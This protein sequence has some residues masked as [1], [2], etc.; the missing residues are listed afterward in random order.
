[1]KVDLLRLLLP[2][3][4]GD[5]VGCGYRSPDGAWSDGG[6]LPLAAVAARFHAKRVEVCLH[7]GDVPAASFA[8]PPLAGRR[9]RAAVLGAIEPCALQPLEGLVAG[10]GPRGAD[11]HVPAAW[12]ARDAMDGWVRLLRQHGLAM[13]ELRLPAAFLPCPAEGWVA[14]RIDQWLVV[15]TGRDQGFTQWLPEG[16]DRAAG[17][18]A[19][20]GEGAALPVVRWVG[21]EDGGADARWSG[22]GWGWSLPAGES[23]A[24]RAGAM[25]AGPLI[26]W[27]ALA[28]IVWL[29]GL[30]IYASHL[31]A[32][33]Q[34]LKRQMAARVKAAYPDIPIVVNPLQQAR[35][36]KAALAAG[37]PASAGSGDLA[38]LMRGASTLLA[39]SS[40]G[41][42]QGLRYTAG[43]LRIRWRDGGAPGADALHALQAQAKEQ[44]WALDSEVGALRMTAAASAPVA[45]SAAPTDA[46]DKK[47]AQ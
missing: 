6:T 33:G 11:G 39:Q 28:V 2:P 35:Q 42:V 1:V 5:L 47:G 43:E 29:A 19:H 14:S 37:A 21:A 8:L 34:A 22:E 23:D 13:R 41:Q 9:L 16:M 40:A 10:F 44:G 18:A 20:A 4:P 32:Q 31:A 38:G 3:W 17:L 7:P 26:A 12:I 36:Q 15:R 30:N 45:E 46:P 27:S 24:G 25:P